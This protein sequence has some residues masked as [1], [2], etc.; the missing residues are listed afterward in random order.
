MKIEEHEDAYKEHLEALN[1]FIEEGI[2]ENQSS[3]S[4]EAR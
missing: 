2:G 3:G 1:K 4:N